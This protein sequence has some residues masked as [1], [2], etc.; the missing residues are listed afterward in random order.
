MAPILTR[1]HA[2]WLATGA[3]LI[4]FAWQL[5]QWPDL[6]PPLRYGYLQGAGSLIAFACAASA[7][8]RYRGTGDFGALTLSVAFLLTGVLE[9]ASGLDVF[10]ALPV[11]ARTSAAIPLA[12]VVKRTMLAVLFVAAV[13]MSNKSRTPQR[14]TTRIASVFLLALGFA[15]L[16]VAACAVAPPIRFIHPNASVPRSFD[17][18]PAGL[19]L[20]AAVGYHRRLKLTGFVFDRGIWLAAIL[21]VG[22]QLAASQSERLLDGP[23][24]LSELLKMA[25]YAVVL[26]G[27][28]VDNARLFEQVRQLAVTD[29]LTGLANYRRLVDVLHTEVQRFERTGR[30]FALLLLDVDD[31]KKINDAHGHLVGSQ[32]LFRLGQILRMESRAVDIPARYGGDEFAV[33]LPDTTAA[34]AHQFARRICLQLSNDRQQPR[35]SVSMGI[36]V[37]PHDGRTVEKILATADVALYQMKERR[38][39]QPPAQWIANCGTPEPRP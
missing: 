7:F 33:V 39:H 6:L 38:P 13:R 2:L 20:V 10:G 15:L 35:F 19:F 11:G 22:C 16:A 36:A 23:F 21:N 26:G 5:R 14:P 24:V 34:A 27:K 18:V 4:L 32:V 9:T 31:L 17:L 25:S 8:V 28:L 30:P 29:A 12:W 37:Y 1:R 3:A